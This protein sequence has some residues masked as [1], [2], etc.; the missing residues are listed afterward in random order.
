MTRLTRCSAESGAV[1]PNVPRTKSPSS[2]M[3]GFSIEAATPSQPPGSWKTTTSP[4]CTGTT[5]GTNTFTIMRSFIWRVS[6]I[7]PEGMKNDLI[8]KAFIRTESSNATPTIATKSTRK[9]RN[10]FL[11]KRR[12]RRLKAFMAPG[13]RGRNPPSNDMGGFY[14]T[15][16][17]F[18]RTFAALPRSLR[19]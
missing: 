9:A 4:R 14:L 18:S 15:L 17:R 5:S 16:S 10:G 6:N 7:E 8:R 2:S 13:F 1:I 12:E 11:R 3:A 19:K